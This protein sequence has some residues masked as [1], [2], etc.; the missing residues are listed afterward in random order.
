M[1]PV[2]SPLKRKVDVRCL[3]A[4]NMKNL[5]DFA[6]C[7]I[8][9]CE[10]VATLV[11]R[12]Q[13]GDEHN[14]ANGLF[15]SYFSNDVDESIFKDHIY[16]THC[17]EAEL[18]RCANC[19]HLWRSPCFSAEA[20]LIAYID[21]HYDARW[22]EETAIAYR[23]DFRKLM[24]FLVRDLGSDVTALEIG[25]QL[26]GF[27]HAAQEFGW[28]VTGVDVGREMVAF[29]ASKG[30]KVLEGT[31]EQA[32]FSDEQFDC[33]C[34]W[35]CF[36]MLPDPRRTL[37]EIG[38]VLKPGGTLYISVPNGDFVRWLQPI[39]RLR[40]APLVRLFYRI[41]SFEILAGFPFQYGYTARSIRELLLE[42]GF[43]TIRTRNQNYIPVSGKCSLPDT[44]SR[45]KARLLTVVYL[46]AQI[47]YVASFGRLL[48]A[49]WM[50]VKCKKS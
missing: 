44:I 18:V 8:C 27:L 31:L 35:L 19:G 13:L 48:S 30:L 7:P 49:P 25:S 20:A 6:E 50:E 29:A 45:K 11:T 28:R 37:V 32:A 24:P 47:I 26:G 33:V 40:F 38:R 23:E 42:Q 46:I 9:H 34:V 4:Y 1:Q 5:I 10:H 43:A 2:S 36:E 12:E 17:Y 39:L 22:M 41:L 21:D 15:R 16:F 14:F 3:W